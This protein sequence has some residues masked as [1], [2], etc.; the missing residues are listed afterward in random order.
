VNENGI[1]EVASRQHA[2]VTWDQA[3]D[4]GFTPTTI[5]R[6]V[7]LG[8]WERMQ[9]GVFRVAGA[10]ESYEQRLLAACLAIGPLAAVSHRAAA[11]LHGLLTFSTPPIE[12][13]TTRARSPELRGDAA[14]HRL[15]DLTPESVTAVAEV[16]CT[17]VAR[18]LVDLGAVCSPSTVEAAVDRALGRHVV[19][20]V[21]LE[22]VVREVG[23]K[24][25]RGVGTMRKVLA[26]RRGDDRPA[27]VLEARMLSLLRQSG[28][29]EPRP[30]Y[31]IRGQRGEFV[32]RVDFAYPGV[33]LAI[34]VDGFEPHTAL[35]VF[36]DDRKRQNRVMALGWTMLRYTWSEVDG[37]APMVADGI[38]RQLRLLDSG[39]SA[40]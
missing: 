36:R 2:L 11:M 28:L 17:S 24:G 33:K 19:T 5:Q 8:R 37:R 14:V 21:D 1:I 32:A 25:R 23:R 13:T 26:N 38:A 16:P 20:I 35:D 18:T 29:P 30:E 3:L 39:Y 15:A 12:V 9:L 10:P 4:R 6:R 31:E 40:R 27:G 22:A 7:E 34:E